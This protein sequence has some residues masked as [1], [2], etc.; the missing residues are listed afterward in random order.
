MWPKCSYEWIL[1]A[2]QTTEVQRL[3]YQIVVNSL[4]QFSPD[5]PLCEV[6]RAPKTSNTSS[7]LDLLSLDLL[8]RDD[9]QMAYNAHCATRVM[10]KSVMILLSGETGTG[11]EAFARAVHN[12][13]N[14]AH[15][16]FVALNCA[17]I[18]E[19]LI[20][21]EL[22]G[23]KHGAFTGARRDGL[24]GRVAESSGGTLFLDE[25]GDMP[26]HLQTRL[27]RV[28][29]DSELRPLG[30]TCPE[31]VDLHVIS[32]TNRDLA[33]LVELGDFR[34]D[35]YYRLNALVLHLPPL[36][37]RKDLARLINMF[38]SQENDEM[39][40]LEVEQDALD[41]LQHYSW[42]G[43]IRELRN[44]LRTAIA[45]SDGNKLRKKDL[46]QYLGDKLAY[47]KKSRQQGDSSDKD[48]QKNYTPLEN[49]EREII[50]S[51]LHSCRWNVSKTAHKL[52]LS[53][54]TLYRK[55]KRLDIDLL[56]S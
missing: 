3:Q 14:R 40:A 52:R 51:T 20:E 53:R 30:S 1:L 7:K 39:G 24:K 10:D 23:Y 16:N 54:S 29:E 32:A 19:T 11:K 4:K 9:P 56:Q 8:C 17:A 21:S 34:E 38:L 13:S 55:A 27:L 18:P 43:N 25:I 33:E 35:L 50:L 28:L 46:P 22:F 37:K 26:C 31:H 12:A 36:R 2:I 45:L 47:R 41:H 42:P 44:V 15:A 6:P 48:S 5:T 49:V